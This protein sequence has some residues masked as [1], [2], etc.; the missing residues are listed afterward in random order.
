MNPS[1]LPSPACRIKVDNSLLFSIRLCHLWFPSWSWNFGGSSSARLGFIL[2]FWGR[3]RPSW[4]CTRL[5]LLPFLQKWQTQTCASPVDILKN[6]AKFISNRGDQV[7]RREDWRGAA[8]AGE[9]GHGQVG[10]A[11]G[12]GRS[13]S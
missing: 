12:A 3:P 10:G 11:V 6:L 9:G 4:H 8:G 5:P 13:Y 2:T 7:V 1:L